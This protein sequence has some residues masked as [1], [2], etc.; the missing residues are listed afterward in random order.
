MEHRRAQASG[1]LSAIAELLV[2]LS[3]AAFNWF[4]KHSDDDVDDDDGVVTVGRNT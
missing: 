2:E 4:T 3:C 1:G